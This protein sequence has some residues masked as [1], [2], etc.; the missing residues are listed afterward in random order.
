MGKHT[1]ATAEV[2]LAIDRCFG[3]CN[4]RRDLGNARAQ[5]ALLENGGGVTATEYPRIQRGATSSARPSTGTPAPPARSPSARSASTTPSTPERLLLARAGHP[6]LRPGRSAPT[7]APRA[8]TR[9]RSPSPTW[10]RPIA[11]RRPS[12]C[13]PKRRDLPLLRHLGRGA[14]RGRGRGAGAAGEPVAASPPGPRGLAATARRSGR[15][16]RRGRRRA[17]RCRR[18]RRGVALPPK[19]TITNAP[20]P[21]SREPP[22]E[23]RLR[24]QPA[25]RLLLL[26]RRRRRAACASPFDAARSARATAR[27]A[28]PSGAIDAAGGSAAADRHLHRRHAGRPG[29]SFAKHPPQAVRTRG[30]SARAAFALR[31]QRGRR[32]VRLQGRPRPAPLLPGTARRG[33]SASAATSL[34]VKAAATRRATSTAPPAVFRFRVKRVG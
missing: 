10:P 32:H 22:A 25:G 33:A 13:R 9:R 26:A 24:R 27:T 8:R 4:P 34:R 29:P 5:V 14:P 11:A 1:G 12:S 23:H 16:A 2:R 31:L 28:S 3:N 30:R 18:R 6:L 21:L 7:P 20:Q 15:S 19:I 17:D